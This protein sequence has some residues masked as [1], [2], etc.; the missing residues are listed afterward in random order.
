MEKFSISARVYLGYGMLLVALVA[1]SVFA[2][3]NVSSLGTTYQGYRG[4]A[5]Q[6]I[7]INNIVED[8]F[9]ARIAALKF[10]ISGSESDALDV[11][12]NIGEILR[13]LEKGTQLSKDT[14]LAAKISDVITL[15]K[16]YDQ[17]FV[18][19][20]EADGQLTT[21]KQ[22]FDSSVATL[23]AE[24][25]SLKAAAVE[26]NNA[27]LVAKIAVTIEALDVVVV[28]VSANAYGGITALLQELENAAA[29]TVE[30]GAGSLTAAQVSSLQEQISGLRNNL[31]EQAKVH[32]KMED[33][34]I[35]GLDTVGPKVQADL[36]SLVNIIVAEQDR[37]GPLGQAKVDRALLMTP[38][39]SGL[40]FVAA[41]IMAFIVGKWITNSIANLVR[42]TMSLAEGDTDV[43]ITGGELKHEIGKMAKA[44]IIFRESIIERRA[45]QVEIEAA[46]EKQQKVVEA[47]QKG[48]ANLA[49]AKLTVRIDEE[50]GAE[51]EVLRNDFNAAVGE[52]EKTISN[53]VETT[54][55]ISAKA[56]EIKGSSS[57]LAARTE[58]QAA[59]LEETAAAVEEITASMKSAADGARSVE[60]I[61]LGATRDAK[62]SGEIVQTA[63]AAMEEIQAFS[64]KI[65]QIIS[66]IDDIAFQT[67][68]LALN[69]GV[70]AARAGEAGRG[71][72]VVA[73]EVRGLAQRCTDAASEIKELI[74]SSSQQVEKGVS[75]V[76]EA[77]EALAG[78]IQQV[79]H[80]SELVS[81]IARSASEQATGLNEINL[82]VTQLDSVTQQNAAM[83]EEA[84]AAGEML[85]RDAEFL[86][87]LVANF[88]VSRGMPL[89]P[90][91][92]TVETD[93]PSIEWDDFA[94]TET[95]KKVSGD[96]WSDF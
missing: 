9:E 42:Q 51:Y 77:G 86:S 73:S 93:L 35:N 52:L 84:T 41:A 78:I 59:T 28:D 50:L 63:V 16:T 32:A 81:N 82:G 62:K 61:V 39:I 91:A 95:P 21:A 94:N 2:Y 15:S 58:S 31:A 6:T 33:L 66:V 53:V 92:L 90:E 8:L 87:N 89:A 17:H 27:Q 22:M 46:Q 96:N 76:G 24:L 71:F 56:D 10:R 64:T 36:E 57:E 44:L 83:V 13:D 47:L 69:A 49:K 85:N 43:K 79:S 11:R 26:Q 19:L 74:T 4:T 70:E 12:S 40:V 68:L 34:R 45:A 23:L 20:Q 1:G 72:A 14:A 5:K 25:R 80:I 29:T 55:S 37:L 88:E 48:L 54:S 75:Y 38:V 3:V 65:S 7:L 60:Q 30:Y 18:D 67:N